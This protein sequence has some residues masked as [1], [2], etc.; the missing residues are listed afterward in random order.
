[1]SEDAYDLTIDSTPIPG[2]RLNNFTATVDPVET[3]DS[4]LHYE[5]GSRWRNTVNGV[6]WVCIDA[7]AGLAHWEMTTSPAVKVFMYAN[8][9]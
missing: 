7:A 8:F 2:R 6:E 5:A 9:V 4:A 1:M 3:D